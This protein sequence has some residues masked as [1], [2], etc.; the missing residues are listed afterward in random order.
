MAFFSDWWHGQT[1]QHRLGKVGQRRVI[2]ASEE[3]PTRHWTSK[4]AHSVV[5]FIAR[6]EK[7]FLAGF[8][9]GLGYLITKL[10]K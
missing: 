4:L 9:A 6:N 10:F 8:I 2:L 1:K 7:T 3:E 5:S